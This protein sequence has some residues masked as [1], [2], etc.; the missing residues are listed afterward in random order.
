MVFYELCDIETMV[1]LSVAQQSYY[2]DVLYC[3]RFVAKLHT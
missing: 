2:V 1:C 3:M